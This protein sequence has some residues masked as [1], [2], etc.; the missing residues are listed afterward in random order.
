M[1][2]ERNIGEPVVNEKM[3]GGPGKVLAKK[4]LVS[5]EE[6]YNKGRVF[7]HIILEKNCGIGEHKHVG[8]A[9][10]YYVLKGHAKYLAPSGETMEVGPGDVLFTGDGESHAITNESDEPF[11]MIAL[12]LYH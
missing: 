6:M 8:D 12:V 3:K 4:I 9:E 11:E 2:F 1:A 7:N 5:D 10:T